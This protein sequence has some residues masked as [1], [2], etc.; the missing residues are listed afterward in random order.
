MGDR[1]ATDI[2]VNWRDSGTCDEIVAYCDCTR[3]SINRIER[4]AQ[5]KPHEA[6]HSQGFAA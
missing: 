4:K 2:A 1:P 3:N 6:F 5:V